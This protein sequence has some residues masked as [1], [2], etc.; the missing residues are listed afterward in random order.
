MR[1]ARRGH[2]EQRDHK[3]FRDRKACQDHQA[4]KAML[5]C[6]GREGQRVIEE[7][8]AC[9]ASPVLTELLERK[10]IK[11]HPDFPD[12]T[13]A[14]APMVG[15]VLRARQEAPAFLVHQA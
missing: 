8:L 7:K 11:D 9:L 4:L 5:A 10:D 1:L 2:L 13:A 6:Q 12:W 14:T 3:A 15:L